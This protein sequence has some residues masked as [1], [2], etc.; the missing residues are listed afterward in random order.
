MSTAPAPEQPAET[1]RGPQPTSSGA[2]PMRVQIWFAVAL[3][4]LFVVL[5]VVMLI[6]AKGSTSQWQN[7]VYV[8]GSVEALVF[9]AIGWVF[10][11]EVQRGQVAAARADAATAKQDAKDNAAKAEQAQ[12]EAAQHQSEVNELATGV[13]IATLAPAPVAPAAPAQRGAEDVGLAGEDAL[14]GARNAAAVGDLSAP[15]AELRALADRLH[16]PA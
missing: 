6:A 16:R 4:A 5:V 10:G 2:P 1:G 9:T 7:M 11:R 3:T 15:L 12:A 13:R 8:F 14:P